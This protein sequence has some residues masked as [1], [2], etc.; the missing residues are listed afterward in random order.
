MESNP[1]DL[2]ESGAERD[3]KGRFLPGHKGIGGRPKGLD[4]RRVVQEYAD[5]RS[6][7][8]EDAIWTIFTSL[9]KSAKDGDVSASRLIL[10]RLCDPD[11]IKL[12]VE[13]SG[14]IGAGLAPPSSKQ[15]ATEMIRL[16]E[17]ADQYLIDSTESDKVQ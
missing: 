6:I 16:K 8:V 17:L 14:E 11:A 10:D 2:A 15:L 13:H 4:F 9:L 1:K 12:S 5:A 3:G 7:K